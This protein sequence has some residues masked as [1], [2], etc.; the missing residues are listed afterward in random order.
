MVEEDEEDDEE[1]D[2][3]DKDNNS[4]LNEWLEVVR[5]NLLFILN[6]SNECDLAE[7]KW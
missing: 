5:F 4:F 2:D 3:D 6:L 7:E 1:E